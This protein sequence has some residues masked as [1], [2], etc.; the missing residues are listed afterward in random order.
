MNVVYHKFFKNLVCVEI[1]S[2]LRNTPNQI[3]RKTFIKSLDALLSKHSA[4][5]LQSVMIFCVISIIKILILLYSGP[6]CRDWIRHHNR[7]YFT[8]P[9]T[10]KVL[11]LKSWLWQTSIIIKCFGRFIDIHLNNSTE[12]KDKT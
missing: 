3:R 12:W 2:F 10:Y 7:P 9:S 4:H 11:L 6:Y 8:N 1:Y 5:D